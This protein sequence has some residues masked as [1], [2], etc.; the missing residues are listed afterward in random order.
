MNRMQPPAMT[1]EST[2]RAA[3][4]ERP[5]LIGAAQSVLSQGLGLLFELGDRSYSRVAGMPFHASIGQHYRHVLEHFQYLIRGVRAAEIN[6]DAGGRNS[7]VETEVTYA[8][9]A[10]CD[11]LRALKTY[12]ESVLLLNCK[13]INT[14]RYRDSE[15]T[16][17]ESNVGRELA[18]CVGH[19]I[20]HYAIIRMVGHEI[21]ITV[22]E[23]FGIAPS[24]QKH[25]NA[26]AAE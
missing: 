2:G 21:G 18:Y 15:P 1:P 22:P 14:V 4:I 7:R 11:V 19:A 26:L 6:Y 23:E 8:S 10:T 20:H 17:L 16:V 5:Q 25:R 13:M 12:T 24:T 9:V 3:S